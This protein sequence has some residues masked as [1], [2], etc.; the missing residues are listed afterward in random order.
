MIIHKIRILQSHRNRKC[1]EDFEEFI[2]KLFT[3]VKNLLCFNK[4]NKQNFKTKLSIFTSN[5]NPIVI[6]FNNTGN[7]K[8]VPGGP[9]APK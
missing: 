1:F 6:A 3:I 9:E 2:T 5:W 8:P 7:P 4:Q